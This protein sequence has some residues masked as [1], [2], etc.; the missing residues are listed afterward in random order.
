MSSLFAFLLVYFVVDNVFSVRSLPTA[1]C[2]SQDFHDFPWVFITDV[3]FTRCTTELGYD[4]VEYNPTDIAE[5]A[6]SNAC[7][8]TRREISTYTAVE[9]ERITAIVG[10][11][12]GYGGLLAYRSNPGTCNE[13]Y[14]YTNTFS[15]KLA[16][17]YDMSAT[18]DGGSLYVSINEDNNP[19][20]FTLEMGTILESSAE[21]FGGAIYFSGDNYL[22][23]RD[24]NFTLCRAKA[25]GGG[26]YMDSCKNDKS[27]NRELLL[28]LLVFF[29]FFLSS[30]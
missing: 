10:H 9:L 3:D 15:L 14:D 26:I 2:G 8:E 12:D 1:G 29:F 21:H 25:D 28:L 7:Y 13:N 30:K 5:F 18:Y 24:V 23:L 16:K 6:K 19:I 4:F 20:T 27:Q 17:V 22:V 11:S